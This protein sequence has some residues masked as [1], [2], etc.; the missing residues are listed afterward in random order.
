MLKKK[1]LRKFQTLTNVI[2][3][4]IILLSFFRL[5]AKVFFV[6]P[7]PVKVDIPTALSNLTNS[8]R[9]KIFF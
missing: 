6:T 1:N 8:R 9:F 2:P 3:F 4:Y 5:F 7:L